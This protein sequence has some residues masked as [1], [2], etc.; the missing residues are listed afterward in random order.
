MQHA[1]HINKIE[2]LIGELEKSAKVLEQRSAEYDHYR[3]TNTN[4][5]INIETLQI[6]N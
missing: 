4:L 2:L 6:D 5:Q 1:E 3:N